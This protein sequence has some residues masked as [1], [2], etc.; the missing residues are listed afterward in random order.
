MHRTTHASHMFYGQWRVL[1][2]YAFVIF[3]RA[4][5]AQLDRIFSMNILLG[6]DFGHTHT[7]LMIISSHRVQYLHHA[8]ILLRIECFSIPYRSNHIY[9]H[10]L[11]LFLKTLTLLSSLCVF[12]K[13]INDCDYT[14]SYIIKIILLV[15][16]MECHMP[17]KQ[18]NCGKFKVARNV[19]ENTNSHGWRTST[20]VSS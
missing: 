16:N 19:R 13:S 17:A 15:Q 4:H 12:F 9:K 8:R 18:K 11:P 2:S 3:S 14:F 7:C 5:W 10:N 1:C 6:H 20:C